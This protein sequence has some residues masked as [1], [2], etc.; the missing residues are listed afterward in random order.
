M[1][2]QDRILYEAI[3]RDVLPSL[4]IDGERLVEMKCFQ[5]ICRIREILSD[6]SLEDPECFWR[7]E[8]IFSALDALGIGGGGR[9]DF[10]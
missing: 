8:E 1:E 6:E 10:G 9:H 2:L 7:I 4:K 3:A 5:T